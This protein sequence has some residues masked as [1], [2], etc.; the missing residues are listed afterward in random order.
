MWGGWR[1]GL[2]GSR[3]VSSFRRW[4]GR[5]RRRLQ[6]RGFTGGRGRG[7]GCCLKGYDAMLPARSR[8]DRIL[9]GSGEISLNC[10]I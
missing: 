6:N 4:R 2:W 7:L 5:G 3:R 8:R 1:G 10:E 9:T